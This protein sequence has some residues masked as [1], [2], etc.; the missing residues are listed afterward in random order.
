MSRKLSESTVVDTPVARGASAPSSDRGIR[1]R[2]RAGRPDGL[3]DFDFSAARVAA[4]LD[5]SLRRLQTDYVDVFQIHDVEFGDE[6]RYD[7]AM[8]PF[9]VPL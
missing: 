1:D 9:S 8:R 4:S 5:E 3:Q 2:Q 6:T 7:A